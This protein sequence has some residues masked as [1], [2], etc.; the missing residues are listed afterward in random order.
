[1]T[2]DAVGGVWTYATQLAGALAPHGVEITL[3]T[4]GARPDRGQRAAIHRLRTVELLESGYRL[5]WMDDP[6]DDVA[7]AGE[8]LLSIAARID[9][10][11]V[12]LNGFAHGALPWPTP[13][14]VVGHSCVLSWWRAVR[15]R[16]APGEWDR[17]RNEVERGL[18]AAALVV[19]PTRT[20]LDSLAADYGPLGATR[21]IVN[22]RDPL[23]YSPAA[24]EPFVL[25][26]GRLWDEAKN[27]AALARIAPRLTCPV[28]V[29]GDTTHPDGGA[30]DLPGV[31]LLGSLP[32]DD[33]ATLF[34]RASVYA[35][36]ARYEP[37][38]LSALEAALA[39]CALVLGDVASLREVWG[40]AAIFV[41]PDDDTALAA[42]IGS[43]ID[44]APA[45]RAMASRARARALTYTAD[46][47][48][49]AYLEE[50]HVLAGGASPV[51]TARPAAHAR[52]SEASAC[53]S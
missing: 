47:M 14:L 35:L 44:D 9:P 38:G 49:A 11:V 22:G 8:W 3:A 13:A 5:E 25:A 36:P 6:W 16:E 17:Y 40:D 19:A 10:D 31:T 30:V 28:L 15:G 29:A 32:S 4:M 27:I 53:A 1:M 2:A 24:K 52:P 33:L 43:L 41:A 42:A 46:R 48:A 23:A 26:A 39:G 20:M 45:R 50:Y 34:G 37:F 7:R 18:H 21:V 51:L 12:H